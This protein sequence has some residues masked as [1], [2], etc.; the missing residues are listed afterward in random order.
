[1]M[2]PE[3]YER[4]R[5]K[6]KGPEDLARELKHGEQMAELRFHLETEPHAQEKLKAQIEKDLSEQGID[7]VV[8]SDALSLEQQKA[9]EQKNFRVTVSSH[10]T[11]HQDQI[12]LMPEGKIQE[13][14]PLT[15]TMSDQY[16]SQFMGQQQTKSNHKRSKK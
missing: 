4:L 11:T 7:A 15:T 5:E 2:S 3:A 8:E 14:I 10:P 16:S 12:M 1:M 13:A 6:V 9:L